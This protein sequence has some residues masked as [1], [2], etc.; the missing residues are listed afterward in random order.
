VS[1]SRRLSP[2]VNAK[3]AC[4]PQPGDFWHEMLC[5][6]CLVVAREGDQVCVCRKKQH[7]GAHYWFVDPEWLAVADFARWLSYR[8]K[9]G[10]WADCVPGARLK[11]VASYL[12]L[13]PAR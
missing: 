10:F 8:T 4:D 2:D 3:H 13:V 11:D 5:A 6:I 12:P 9:D 7:D 1:A